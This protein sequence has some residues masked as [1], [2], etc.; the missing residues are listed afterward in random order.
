VDRFLLDTAVFV[1]AIGRDHPFREPCRAVV[2]A[3]S[4]GALAGEASVELVQELVH[5]LLGRP[6][7]RRSALA[8]ARSFGDA[9]RLHDFTTADL[10]LAL[11]LLAAVPQ[12]LDARDAVHAATALN[13][14]VPFVVTTDRAFDSVPG[15]TRVDPRDAVAML[16]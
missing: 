11:E 15:L 7:S 16:T 6:G 13:R 10:G 3:L 12:R 14:G 5:V 9:C 1:H 4:G 8:T 2:A